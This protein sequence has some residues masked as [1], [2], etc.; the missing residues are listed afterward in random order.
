MKKTCLLIVEDQE[1]FLDLLKLVASSEGYY[2]ATASDGSE[3]VELLKHVKPAL[4][5]TD[6]MMPHLDGIGLIEYVKRTPGL[7]NIPVVVITGASGKE[8]NK[9]KGAGAAKVIKK[10]I[11]ITEFVQSL[12]EYISAH[13]SG[14]IAAT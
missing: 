11:E 14:P 9:A 5:V 6:L 13:K 12:R 1:D 7:K 8:V 2:A 3:A 4:I 10:P